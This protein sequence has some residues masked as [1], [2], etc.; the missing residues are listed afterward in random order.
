MTFTIISIFSYIVF[1]QISVFNMLTA[2]QLESKVTVLASSLGG[3]E[4]DYLNIYRAVSKENAIEGGFVAVR[5]I[6]Y[7]K[8][9]VRTGVTYAGSTK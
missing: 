2:K 4:S 7:V 3:I 1:V 9:M 5:N 8:S 6:S